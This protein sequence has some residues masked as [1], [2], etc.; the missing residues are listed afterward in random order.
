MTSPPSASSVSAPWVPVSPRSSPGTASRSSASSVDD[1]SSSPRGRSTRRA[2]DRTCGRPRQAHRAGAD[3]SWS[4]GSL[5][6]HHD[7][8]RRRLR[9]RGRGRS[10]APRPSSGRSSPSS[11]RLV[12]RRHRPRHQHV[13]ALGDADRGRHFAA[14]PRGR[15]ALLQPGAGAGVLRGHPHRRG[16]TRRG[17]RRAPAL[18]PHRLGK[19][20]VVAGDKAG[21]IANAL[22]F[23]YLNHA[24]S[25][26]EGHYATRE[27]IDAAM[28]HHTGYPMG[29]WRCS[30]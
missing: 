1:E 8:R 29:R 15:P 12:P 7:G 27:D 17:R 5:F 3:P 14:A 19:N 25:L 26:Y 9:P 11:I 20:P 4:T 13:L 18:A 22:L 6:H 21:F 16:R 30:T 28:R 23:G 10:R 2:L 24:A